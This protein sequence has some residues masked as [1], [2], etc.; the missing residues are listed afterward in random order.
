ML[1][2]NLIVTISFMALLACMLM[3]IFSAAGVCVVIFG[4]EILD[5]DLGSTPNRMNPPFIT[6]MVLMVPGMLVG[7]VGAIFGIMIPLYRKFRIPLERSNEDARRW[8]HGYALGLAEYTKP[9][10]ENKAEKPTPHR[11]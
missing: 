4:S 2:K 5:A 3:G 11:S 6:F 9:K 8:L 10:M 7:A 1:I